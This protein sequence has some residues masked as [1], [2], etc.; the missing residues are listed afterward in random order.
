[1]EISFIYKE[2]PDLPF[3]F[4]KAVLEYISDE[5]DG[6]DTVVYS[7]VFNAVNKYRI[8]D[9]LTLVGTICL[10]VIGIVNGDFCSSNEKNVFD[11]YIKEVGN[12]K[13][14]YYYKGQKL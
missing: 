1:M 4:G 11:L 14:K 12:N 7:L 5:H 13:Y 3:K 9:D 10:G 2:F 6:L 8:K